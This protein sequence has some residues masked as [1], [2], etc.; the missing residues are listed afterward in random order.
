MYWFTL[1]RIFSR[2]GRYIGE[3]L[4]QLITGMRLKLDVAVVK[5]S[6]DLARFKVLPNVGLWSEPLA[7]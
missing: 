5:S 6:D 7:G 3:T 2:D 4:D 1:L